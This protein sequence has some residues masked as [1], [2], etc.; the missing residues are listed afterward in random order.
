MFI[1]VLLPAPFS[2]EQGEHLALGEVQVD[3]IVGQH[4]GESAW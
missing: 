1:R 2:P 3:V 4:A